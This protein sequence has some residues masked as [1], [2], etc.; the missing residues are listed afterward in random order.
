MNFAKFS[1][2]PFLTEH[3]QWLLL[4]KLFVKKVNGRKSLTDSSKRYFLDSWQDSEYVS[5]FI[6]SI[7]SRLS[8]FSQ[9]PQIPECNFLRKVS[10]NQKQPSRGVLRKRCSE[11]MQQIYRRTLIPKLLCNFIEIAL[12]H[13]GS[14]VNLLHIFRAPFSR[15]TCGWLLLYNVVLYI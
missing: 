7:L 15:N 10:Y 5:A 1:R 11:N 12:R 9:A 2:T 4:M 8:I 6:L 3:L 13:G 14:P